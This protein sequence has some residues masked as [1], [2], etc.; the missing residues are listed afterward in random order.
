ML[1]LVDMVVHSR[2][3]AFVSLWAFGLF[4]M[5]FASAPFP[6]TEEQR[7]RF[8]SLLDSANQVEGFEDAY[9][10]WESKSTRLYNAKTFLWWMSS[11]TSE[12]VYKLQVLARTLGL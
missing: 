10:E 1:M 4:C 6:T 11:Q 9:N 8:E 2:S 3:K 12:R 7:D 5:L